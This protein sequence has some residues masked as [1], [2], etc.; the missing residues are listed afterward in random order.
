M[1]DTVS[2]AAAL[3]SE[4]LLDIMPLPDPLCLPK[5]LTLPGP[6]RQTSVRNLQAFKQF[7]SSIFTY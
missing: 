5:P 7:T 1:I 2:V 4:P 6:V 3:F